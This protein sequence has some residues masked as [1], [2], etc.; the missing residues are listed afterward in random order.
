MT[1]TMKAALLT[2]V[3]ALEIRE[4]PAPVISRADDVL[5]RSRAVGICGSD[6]HYYLSDSVGTDRVSYPFIPGHECAGVVEAVG[7]DPGDDVCPP[8]AGLPHLNVLRHDS[9]AQTGDKRLRLSHGSL[10]I[11]H[12]E[13]DGA[14]PDQHRGGH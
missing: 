12:L 14:G 1:K 6:L 5:V 9:A 11:S 8:P 2:G 4:V 3:R 10:K 7:G 13:L